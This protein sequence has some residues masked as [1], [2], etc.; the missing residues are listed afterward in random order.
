MADIGLSV[1]REAW[2]RQAIATSLMALIFV[3]GFLNQFLMGRSTFAAPLVVHIHA[4]V[5]FGWVAINTVQAWAAASGRLDLHRPLGWL[6]AA[7]V[8]MM[9]AAGVAIMLERVGTGRT[10]FFFQPQVFVV[11][12]LAGLLCF[13]LLTG[14]A[15]RLRHDTGW[16]R[17][18]HMCAFASLMGPAFG[19]I[20]PMPLMIPWALELAMLPGLA[21]PAWLAWRERREEGAVHPAWV[22]GILAL[23]LTTLVAWLIAQS[24]VGDALYAAVVAGG[25]A[26]TV[27]G[28]AFPPP[29]PMG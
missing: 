1:E 20:L 16:H 13:A 22:I 5:F 14:A 27:P 28:L 10:P 6:A 23:P 7:W 12:N 24:P 25:P 21:F 9:L 18:L 11:E 15:I 29:P 17:R 19:R 2:R 3:A 26:E 8:L 4:L